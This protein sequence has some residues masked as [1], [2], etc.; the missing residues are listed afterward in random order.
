[1]LT[2]FDDLIALFSSS[3]EK[4]SLISPSLPLII[5]MTC[6]DHDIQAVISDN[7]KNNRLPNLDFD[8]VYYADDTILASKDPDALNELLEHTEK[9]SA[10][11]G[12]K[13]N[14]GKCVSINMN[15]DNKIAFTDGMELTKGKQTLY[16]GN[17]INDKANLNLEITNKMHEV[18]KTWYK[19]REYWKAKDASK[20][21]QII[22]YDAVIRSKLLYGLETVQLTEAMAKK[23]NAFQMRGLRQILKK[24]HTFYNRAHSNQHVI[25]EGNK[26]INKNRKGTPKKI[27]LFSEFHEERK[28]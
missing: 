16:L 5:V 20:K 21:W 17:E 24:N 12:L 28:I 22:I 4:S 26:E 1:M 7:V 19:M 15:N 9:S 8:M 2:I 13:L 3:I 18:R 6:I 27:K 11:Y 25:D 14:K 23:L 10:K